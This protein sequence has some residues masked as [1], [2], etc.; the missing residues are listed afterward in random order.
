MGVLMS[1]WHITGPVFSIL[2]IDRELELVEQALVGDKST[3]A[4]ARN[5]PA[6]AS[7]GN[8]VLINR[9][10]VGDSIENEL[11]LVNAALG[12]EVGKIEPQTAGSSSALTSTNSGFVAPANSGEP[13]GSMLF[14]ES[15]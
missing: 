15:L 14:S 8:E 7:V 3:E 4:N 12:Q 6:N 10:G 1:P 2:V 11:A 9:D 13:L 5:K